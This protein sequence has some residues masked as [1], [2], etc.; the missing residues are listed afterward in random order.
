MAASQSDTEA[1]RLMVSG[2]R[3]VARRAHPLSLASNSDSVASPHAARILGEVVW[4]LDSL[5]GGGAAL[6]R[7]P[8]SI[9]K[10]GKEDAG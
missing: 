2:A 7:S 3:A 8:F 5:F 1:D 6:G 9:S 10:V 4:N